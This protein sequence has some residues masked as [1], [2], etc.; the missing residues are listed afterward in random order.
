MSLTRIYSLSYS[1]EENI[2]SSWCCI[3]TLPNEKLIQFSFF[4][5]N[6]REQKKIKIKHTIHPL[7]RNMNGTLA[8]VQISRVCCGFFDFFFIKKWI[9][10]YIS[11]IWL[12]AAIFTVESVAVNEIWIFFVFFLLE[13]IKVQKEDKIGFILSTENLKN[14]IFYSLFMWFF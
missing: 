9:F 5:R 13:N 7:H 4:K 12:V 1:E 10:P 14:A 8:C 6:R 2:D 11:F 3:Q